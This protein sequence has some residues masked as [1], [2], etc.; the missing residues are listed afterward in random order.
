MSSPRRA[1]KIKALFRP[2]VGKQAL[3]MDEIQ[4][5]VNGLKTRKNFRK[6]T[7]L[8]VHSG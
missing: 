3:K 4:N 7:S 8:N 2:R 5:V 6:I 1:D